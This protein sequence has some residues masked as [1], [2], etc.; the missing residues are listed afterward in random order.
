M[1]MFYDLFFTLALG[2]GPSRRGVAFT[3]THT[4]LDRSLDE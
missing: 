3:F 4:T 1:F 2:P